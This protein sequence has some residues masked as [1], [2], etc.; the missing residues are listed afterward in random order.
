MEAKLP[1]N[2]HSL[3]ALGGLQ[4]NTRKWNSF[5][6]LIHVCFF[7]FRYAHLS[8]YS[9]SG[10]Y[11]EQ[12]SSPDCDSPAAIATM[13]SASSSG[14]VAEA[15][16]FLW[17]RACTLPPSSGVFWVAPGVL[18]GM[19]CDGGGSK[20]LAQSMNKNQNATGSSQWA[21]VRRHPF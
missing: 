16:C 9:C 12:I 5:M 1:D 11:L 14:W 8:M 7:M 3:R 2:T 18:S 17:Y 21:E 10:V 13:L 6:V 15:I 19:A 4:Y 20:Q